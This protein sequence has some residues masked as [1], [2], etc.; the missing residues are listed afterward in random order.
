MDLTPQQRDQI[1][2]LFTTWYQNKYGSNWK[3]NFHKHMRPTPIYEWARLLDV[4]V[5]S[6]KELKIALLMTY[7]F[8]E[9]DAH[10]DP[11]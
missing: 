3:K 10:Y 5:N 8:E 1:T 7:T 11:Y 2:S 9:F 6:I 4:N